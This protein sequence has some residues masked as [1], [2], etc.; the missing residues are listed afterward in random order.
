ME[1]GVFRRYHAAADNFRAHIF[2]LR[3]AVG[4]LSGVCIALLVLLATHTSTVRLSLPPALEYG[5]EF[6]GGEI[7]PWEVFNFTGYV[8]QQFKYM[9]CRWRTGFH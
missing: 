5:G 2:S 6:A 7:H 8:H 3:V 1:S 4:V 9:A